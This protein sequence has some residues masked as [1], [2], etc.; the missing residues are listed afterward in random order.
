MAR[1][2]TRPAFPL[3]AGDVRGGYRCLVPAARL[4]LVVDGALVSRGRGVVR[5]RHRARWT[6]RARGGGGGAAWCR[7]AR[8]DLVAGG[9]F[10]R[11]GTGAARDRDLRGTG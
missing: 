4:F 6:G 9:E 5:G 10:G 2:R 3:G 11:A 8:I 7:R 1:G